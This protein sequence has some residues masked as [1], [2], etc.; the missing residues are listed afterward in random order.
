MESRLSTNPTLTRQPR[1][2]PGLFRA[3]GFTGEPVRRPAV[4]RAPWG[5]QIL[6]LPWG[7]QILGPQILGP[8]ILGPIRIEKEEKPGNHMRVVPVGDYVNA[9]RTADRR[10][11]SAH[12]EVNY[13]DGATSY[14]RNRYHRA[15]RRA[16]QAEI[17]ASLSLSAE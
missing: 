11:S 9:T 16:A 7:P 2:T 13:R 10:L 3:C 15:S 12:S 6:G 5:P 14:N 8:Q 4:V 17:A 1:H